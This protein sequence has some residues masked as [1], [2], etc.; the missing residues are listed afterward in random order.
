MSL[1]RGA[2]VVVQREVA[3]PIRPYSELEHAHLIKG[4]GGHS[5][6]AAASLFPD[7]IGNAAVQNREMCPANAAESAFVAH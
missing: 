5:C 7:S 2:Y 3:S 1:V 6:D 4:A